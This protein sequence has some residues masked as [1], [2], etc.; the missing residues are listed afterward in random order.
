MVVVYFLWFY[1]LCSYY[2]APGENFKAKAWGRIW[3]Q[4]LLDELCTRD[5]ILF[6]STSQIAPVGGMV[7]EVNCTLQLQE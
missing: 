2:V 3:R 1:F 7:I 6:G 5:H 4:S